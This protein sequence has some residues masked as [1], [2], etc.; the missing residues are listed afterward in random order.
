MEHDTVA[1][2]PARV[3]APTLMNYALFL[4]KMHQPET[5]AA[6]IGAVEV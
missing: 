5:D 4:E 6:I 1:T 2:A 3:V